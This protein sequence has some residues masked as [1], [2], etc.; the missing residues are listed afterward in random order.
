[1]EPSIFWKKLGS[2]RDN[3]RVESAE[4]WWQISWINNLA[5]LV[6]R[7][8]DGRFY[9]TSH[10]LN[11]FCHELAHIKHMNHL[12]A[13]HAYWNRLKSGC[14]FLPRTSNNNPIYRGSGSF[15]TGRIL[16]RWLLVGWTSSQRRCARR[17]A[18]RR[19]R[20]HSRVPSRSLPRVMSAIGLLKI[21]S[22]V[23]HT[24]NRH[25]VKLLENVSLGTRPRLRKGLEHK[26]RGRERPAQGS[27]L[28][29]RSKDR[30]KR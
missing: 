11:V 14:H 2:R 10:L 16:W 28:R 15:A 17:E 18:R 3:R 24:K 21:V 9:G 12:P 6:L 5:E 8:A 7:R 26:I 27:R 20:G 13:F 23:E 29:M 4:H 22:V 19:R 30:A 25:R 1:M